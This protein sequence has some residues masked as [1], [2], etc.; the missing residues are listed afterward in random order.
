LKPMVPKV[1][2]CLAP[3]TGYLTPCSGG[4]NPYFISVIAIQR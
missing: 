1:E 4:W 3:Y 2:T